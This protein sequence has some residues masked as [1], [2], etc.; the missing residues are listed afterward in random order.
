[1]EQLRI[2]ADQFRKQGRLQDEDLEKIIS[3]IKVDNG[4]KDGEENSK[5]ATSYKDKQRR[6][7]KVIKKGLLQVHGMAPTTKQQGIF[8]SMGENYNGFNNRIG[9][10]KKI[11]KVLDI[12][13]DFDIYCHLYCKHRLNFLHKDNKNDLKQMFQRELAWVAI[14]AHNVHEAKFAGR[15]QESNAGTICSGKCNGYIKKTRCDNKGLGRWSWILLG[16]VDGH[17]AQII[18]VYNPCKNKNV[19]LVRTYQQQRQY[20]ISWNKDLTCPL[21]LFCKYLVKQIKQWQVAGDRIILFVDH[22]ECVINGDLGKAL[23]EKDG[24]YLR[25]AIVL[26]TGTSPGATSFYGSKPINGLWISSDLNISNACVMPFSY[27]I[28]N[29]HTFILDIP[30]KLL[31]S[32]DSVKI[33]QPAGQ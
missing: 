21:I 18:T 31:V 4:H 8:Q 5:A 7:P 3:E 32:V 23:A 16:G 20:F 27:G 28:G 14:S 22:K 1:M 29:H 33:A 6:V 19:N 13:E 15:F 9:G 12:K 24:L 26:H 17:N 2:I 30:I 10:N 25:E 11:A